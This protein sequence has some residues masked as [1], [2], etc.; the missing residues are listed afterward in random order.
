MT[1]LHRFSCTALLSLALSGGV[2]AMTPAYAAT[3]SAVQNAPAASDSA[4]TTDAPGPAALLT[5]PGDQP[6]DFGWQ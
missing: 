5:P 4:T 1:R 2:L 6:H 3:A